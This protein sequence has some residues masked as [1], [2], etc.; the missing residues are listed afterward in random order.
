MSC[1]TRRHDKFFL[2][3]E[4]MGVFKNKGP[5]V[6]TPTECQTLKSFRVSDQSQYRE[7]KSSRADRAEQSKREQ[8][9]LEQTRVE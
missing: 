9:R 3:F 8:S 1:R 6:Q 2:G 4:D 7:E 5:A